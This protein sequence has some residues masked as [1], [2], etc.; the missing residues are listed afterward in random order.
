M[1]HDR[2]AFESDHS[3]IFLSLPTQ[4]A[5]ATRTPL[6][7]SWL[8][9]WFDTI[10]A[11]MER[12]TALAEIVQSQH[13]GAIPDGPLYQELAALE[14][15]TNQLFDTTD[16]AI[17]AASVQRLS[18]RIDAVLARIQEGGSPDAYTQRVK[19][20]ASV[21]EQDDARL[22]HDLYQEESEP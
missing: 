8:Q 19:M 1:E 18:E 17:F 4:I 10:I 16:E 15:A 11:L 12:Q 9:P 5:I 20:L 13:G 14:I 6:A 3:T 2:A 7:L 21:P 22:H